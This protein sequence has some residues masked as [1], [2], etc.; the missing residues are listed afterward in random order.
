MK[1]IL[2]LMNKRAAILKRAIAK[3]EAE[4]GSFPDGHLRISYSNN[5][6]RYYK[7][8][9]RGDTKGEYIVKER[10]SEATALAQ[11]DYNRHFLKTAKAEL[12]RLERDIRFF[13]EEN[14]DLLFQDLT[15]NRKKLITPYILT[16]DQYVKEWLA[17]DFKPNPYM[18]EKKIYATN[19]GEMV[20]SKSEAILADILYDMGIPYHYEKLLRLKSG[21]GVYPDFTLLQIYTRKEIYLEHF[22]LLEDEEY[23]R[24]TLAKLDEYRESGIFPGKNLLFTYETRDSPFDI[25]GIRKMLTELLENGIR[26]DSVKKHY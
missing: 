10:R 4:E 19:R 13:S 25:K 5:R 26:V 20:R 18:P 14:A 22:G 2:R 17:K 8:S 23:L 15:E 6:P 12:G 11:K 9:R 16:D 21:R 3:A 24:N 7:M 1:D